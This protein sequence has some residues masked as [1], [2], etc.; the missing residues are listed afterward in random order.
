VID[1]PE[2]VVGLK[3]LGL[4]YEHQQGHLLARSVIA[5][6]SYWGEEIGQEGTEEP[7]LRAMAEAWDWLMSMRLVAL[8]PGQHALDG[9]AYIT[10]RG[11]RVLE[12][13]EPI[14]L[15][16]A[17]ERIAVDLHA[18]IAGVVRSQFLLGQY[19]L[20]ALAAMKQVEIRVRELSQRPHGDIGVRLMRAAFGR[21]DGDLSDPEQEA[22]ERQATSD[23]FAGAI[24]VFKNPASHREVEY[25]DPTFASEV[26]M[27]ADLLLRMLDGVEARLTSGGIARGP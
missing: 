25:D 24:G 23:L 17:E 9:H 1:L 8:L 4:A 26:I 15:L 13:T 6:A 2:D 27:L 19:E 5:N 11:L 3:L 20:A 22:G 14:A 18:S 12:E 10:R 21:D 16:R 7:F